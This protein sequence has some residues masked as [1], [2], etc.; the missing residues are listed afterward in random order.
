MVIRWLVATCMRT[1]V[2]AVEKSWFR[3]TRRLA[4]EQWVRI[5]AQC[6]GRSTRD[7]LADL[8]SQPSPASRVTEA[9]D[10][11]LREQWLSLRD[12]AGPAQVSFVMGAIHAC[13][14]LVPFSP[15]HRE[16]WERRIRTCPGHDDEGGRSWCAFCGSMKGTR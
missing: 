8:H 10:T 16:L 7:V 15:E 13:A 12:G 5:V 14:I 6:E 2:V 11:F 3:T 9:A 1:R 4:H